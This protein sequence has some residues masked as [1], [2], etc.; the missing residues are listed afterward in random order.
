MTAILQAPPV[1][2]PVPHD[3]PYP[4]CCVCGFPIPAWDL[5]GDEYQ[6]RHASTCTNPSAGARRSVSIEPKGPGVGGAA[7]LGAA[8]QRAAVAG[9]GGLLAVPPLTVKAGP[10]GLSR[11]SPCAALRSAARSDEFQTAKFA[12]GGSACS[13]L[14]TEPPAARRGAGAGRQGLPQQTASNSDRWRCPMAIRPD[15]EIAASSV[16]D[17][18]AQAPTRPGPVLRLPSRQCRRTPA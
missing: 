15:R 2:G 7:A 3:F 17:R 8:V 10:R 14:D 9:V 11:V 1:A 4:T 18:P 12:S 13:G 5:A 16:V 6:P